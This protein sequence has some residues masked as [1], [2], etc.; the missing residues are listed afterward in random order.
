M[1]V[2][3]AEDLELTLREGILMLSETYFVQIEEKYGTGGY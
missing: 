3:A 2:F 1:W